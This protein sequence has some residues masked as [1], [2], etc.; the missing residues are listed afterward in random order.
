MSSLRQ[1]TCQYPHSSS[2]PVAYKAPQDAQ[3]SSQPQCSGDNSKGA[4]FPMGCA[5]LEP[6][7]FH[8]LSILFRK[9]TVEGCHFLP[10]PS[11]NKY[12][13]T[14]MAT[15]APA[16]IK[17]PVSDVGVAHH[18]CLGSAH[19]IKYI[20]PIK[21]AQDRKRERMD[22]LG[23]IGFPFFWSERPIYNRSDPGHDM[24][25]GVRVEAR[26]LPVTE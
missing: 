13:I 4:F 14:K 5:G 3:H 9:F 25:H 16:N 22:G 2:P 24:P 10:P 1:L 11:K 6:D 23:V 15:S 21:T 17:N 26:E 8:N 12:K 20:D 19:A 18:S 7:V